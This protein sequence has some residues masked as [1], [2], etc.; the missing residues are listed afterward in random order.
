MITFSQVTGRIIIDA[1]MHSQFNQ[2]SCIS[3]KI[4]GKMAL[5]AGVSSGDPG[6]GDINW[7]TS[8]DTEMSSPN[9]VDSGER[10]LSSSFLRLL[11][12]KRSRKAD[13]RAIATLLSHGQ[14]LL[15]DKQVL[16]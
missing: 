5:P 6:H 14:G 9:P 8:D 12:S 1:K 15:L 13:R 11:T 2:A 10:F 4:G 16:G 3:R 7:E